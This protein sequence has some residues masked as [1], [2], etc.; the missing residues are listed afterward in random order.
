MLMF[1][2]LFLPVVDFT[3]NPTSS[4]TPL[5][6]NASFTCQTAPADSVLHISWIVSPPSGG[7]FDTVL[8]EER[9]ELENRG[10]YLLKLGDRQ[11]N[12]MVLASLENNG[13]SVS[14]R[15]FQFPFQ[16]SFSDSANLTV[17]GN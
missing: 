3:I 5:G 12:L 17:I 9:N 6:S 13:T 11:L 2:F 4:Y 1:N 8:P 10:I 15:E 14:C 16:P 7:R